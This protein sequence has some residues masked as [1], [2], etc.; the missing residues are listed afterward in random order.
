MDYFIDALKKYTDFSTRARRKD[1]W[2][3]ILFYVIF[4][5]VTSII[6]GVLG[7][8][9]ITLIFSLAML[10]P[11]ISIGAR[12]L[13]DTGRTGWWQLIGLIPLI[14]AIVLIVFYVQD[15][16]ED[17]QYGVSPKAV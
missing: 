6:D 13:H 7:T 11:S 14:G 10:I 16:H 4:Y 8:V 5:I 17:N 2:M 3:F 12:R 1:Y 9:F 15:S